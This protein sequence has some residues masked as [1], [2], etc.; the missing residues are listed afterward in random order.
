MLSPVVDIIGK[1]VGH[2][3]EIVLHDLTCPG[4]SILKIVNG[5]VSGRAVGD[6][7]LSGPDN[8]KAFVELQ[9]NLTAD[10]G[11]SHSV[12]SDYQT[13]TRDGRELQSTTVIFLDSR[14]TP[15][16]SLCI[17]ADMS[18]VVQA[19][20]LLQSMFSRQAEPEPERAAAPGIDLLMKEIITDAVNK[21]GKKVSAMGKQEKIHAVNTMLQR[22]LFTVKGGVERAARALGVTRFTIYNYLD[23]LRHPGA[24]EGVAKKA[25]TRRS[26]GK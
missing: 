16:A 13:F 22:G 18:V 20:A 25:P 3:V 7:I 19:H 23:A 5:E 1:V 11:A 24:D 8:D 14:H 4:N 9:R 21:F 10:E 15:F 26:A 2:N 12:I 6:S 17:N